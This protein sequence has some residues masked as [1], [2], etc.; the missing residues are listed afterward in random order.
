MLGGRRARVTARVVGGRLIQARSEAASTH[1]R[2]SYRGSL[3]NKPVYFT[4]SAETIALP[5]EPWSSKTKT[6]LRRNPTSEF[7]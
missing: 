7:S 2:N 6:A 4:T 1:I 3:R 5:L